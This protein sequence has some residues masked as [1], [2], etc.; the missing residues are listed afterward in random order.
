M[1]QAQNYKNEYPHGIHKNKCKKKEV[2]S[3]FP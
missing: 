2:H 3:P 1:I